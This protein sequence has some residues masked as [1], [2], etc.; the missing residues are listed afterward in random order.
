METVKQL[1]MRLLGMDYRSK[2]IR[3]VLEAFKA[4]GADQEDL[5]RERKRLSEDDMYL[6]EW[7]VAVNPPRKS[8]ALA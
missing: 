8:R 3:E 5:E 7:H 2:C 4:M 1:V 6:A